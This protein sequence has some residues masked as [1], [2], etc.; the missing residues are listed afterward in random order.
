MMRITNG[1]IADNTMRNINKAANRLADAN[2]AVSS[3]QKIQKASDDPV[4]AARAVTYRSYV[5][6][7]KQYQDNVEAA[8]GWQSTTDDA[9]SQLSDVITTVKTLTNQAASTGTLSDSDL[10]DIKSR[11]ETLQTEALNLLNSTYNGKYI[12]GGYSTTEESYEVATTDIGDMATYKGKYLNLCGVVNSDVSDTDILSFYNSNTPN[13]Y[14]SLGDA[15]DKALTAYNTA[16]ALADANPTDT[17]LAAK[18]ASAKTTSDILADAASTYGE[19]VSMSDAIT[20]AQSAYDTK[21]TAYETAKAAADAD[22]TDTTLAT[23]AANAETEMDEAKTTLD[24]LNT[25]SKSNDQSIKYNIGFSSEVTVNTEG[26]DVTGEGSGN[27]FDTFAK[28]LL[29]LD[30]ETSY[31]SVTVDSAGIATVTTNELNL[32]DL[33]DELESNLDQVTVAQAALGARRNVV[34]DASDSLGDAYTAYKSYMTD[35]EN[36][37][38]AEAATELT[39]AEYTYEASLAVGAKVISK[40]L[41]DYIG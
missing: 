10:S 17:T 18:A 36:I 31:K 8:D 7:I 40:S 9:L 30:G 20:S 23:A 21:K 3:N 16:Q 35:N 27:L 14:D 28:L 15:A 32:S 24:T 4:V 22:P 41:I 39:S 13:A 26:Q 19:G 33:L 37:D 38:T 34:S 29:A 25:A 12:F 1:M 5:S 6:Q 11:V 2:A